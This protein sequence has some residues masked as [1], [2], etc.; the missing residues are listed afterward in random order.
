MILLTEYS[1]IAEISGRF[2]VNL[3][4]LFCEVT[5][6]IKTDNGRDLLDG[7]AGVF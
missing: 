6:G 4:K 7:Q 1:L 2:S 5:D 3:G